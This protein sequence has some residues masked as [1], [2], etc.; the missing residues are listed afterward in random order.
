[1]RRRSSS[2]RG[3]CGGSGGSRCELADVVDVLVQQL[4]DGRDRAIEIGGL[5]GW[6]APR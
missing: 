3:A 1:M 2:A 6:R 4:M 5:G